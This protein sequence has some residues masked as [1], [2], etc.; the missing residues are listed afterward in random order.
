MALS[1]NGIINDINVSD[2]A[3]GMM[4]ESYVAEQLTALGY[5]LHYWA[6]KNTAEVDFVIQQE[7]YSIPV[8][9]KSSD[10]AKAKSLKTYIEKYFPPYAIRIYAKNFGYENGIKS[11]PLYAV[12]CL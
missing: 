11:I 2:K 10:N 6:S 5:P 7:E 8:E 1:P 4:A 9:V 3:K 12:F